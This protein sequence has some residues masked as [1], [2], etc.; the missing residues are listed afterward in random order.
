MEAWF[1]NYLLQ[2]R[3]TGQRPKE[4]VACDGAV[5]SEEVN[6]SHTIETTNEPLTGLIKKK[7]KLSK[8][9]RNIIG[10]SCIQ[11]KQ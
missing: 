5:L 8:Q 7:M 10:A 1:D 2:V 11:R 9:I 4:G 6:I 3:G